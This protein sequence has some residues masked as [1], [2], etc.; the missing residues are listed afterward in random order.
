[1][2]TTRPP[3]CISLADHRDGDRRVEHWVRWAFVVALVV[4]VAAGLLNVFGQREVTTSATGRA[5]TLEVTAPGALRG[6]LIFQGRFRLRSEG[7]ITRPT[8]ALEGGWLDGI[9]LNTVQPEPKTS[10]GED[11]GVVFTFDRLAPGR[12]LTVYLELQVNP[13][14]T[15]RRSQGVEL[16]DGDRTLARVERSI[17]IFP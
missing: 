17:T 1:M 2:S 14:T 10:T 16:R 13:T 4:L 11:G 8:L 15:G 7:A 5:A 12:S 6:G 3:D 9:T